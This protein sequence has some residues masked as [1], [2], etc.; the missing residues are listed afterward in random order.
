MSHLDYYQFQTEARGVRSLDDVRRIAEQKAYLYDQLVQRWLPADKSRPVAELACGHGS[1]LYWLKTRNFSAIAGVDS[2]A[3]QVALAR[4]VSVRVDQDDVNRWLARQPQNHFAALV[5]I[6][7]VEHLSKDDFMVFLKGAHSAL[8]PGGSLILR[9]PNGDSPF[10]GLNLFNDITHVWTY[11]P[12]CLNS[13]AQMH[14]FART[15][16]ADE[17]AAA[18]RDHRWLKVA[19]AKLSALLLR[20]LTQAATREKV[21]YWSPNLWA[22]LVR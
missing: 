21:D 15:E 10:V 9:L 3:E 19:L 14:G 16:F 7:L 20:A 4:Q 6:D 2:S 1:F 13:L 18:I 11:T 22:R 8:A 5:A 12:N 17:G